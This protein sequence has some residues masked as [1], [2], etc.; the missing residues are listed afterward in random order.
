MT[1][2]PVSKVTIISIE[3]GLHT[4]LQKCNKTKK[5]VLLEQK[6][7]VLIQLIFAMTLSLCSVM[8]VSTIIINSSYYASSHASLYAMSY[9]LL[10]DLLPLPKDTP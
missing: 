8:F 6:C 3:T 1:M 10:V 2:G 9:L 7:I 4:N 5:N